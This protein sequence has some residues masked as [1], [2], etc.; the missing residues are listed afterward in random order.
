MYV[1]YDAHGDNEIKPITRMIAHKIG[2]SGEPVFIFYFIR[3]SIFYKKMVYNVS[4]TSLVCSL[5]FDDSFFIM[6]KGR[7][8]LLKY[9]IPSKIINRIKYLCEKQNNSITDYIKTVTTLPVTKM[10]HNF[11]SDSVDNSVSLNIIRDLVKLYFDLVWAFLTYNDLENLIGRLLTSTSSSEISFLLTPNVA[12]IIPAPAAISLGIV[13]YPRIELFS[14]AVVYDV[15][16]NVMLSI[17][18]LDERLYQDHLE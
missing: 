14:Q 15:S 17:H 13:S 6:E 7:R 8:L 5:H 4:K 1:P 10:F 2:L 12:T 11:E 16:L 18:P 3:S 9:A